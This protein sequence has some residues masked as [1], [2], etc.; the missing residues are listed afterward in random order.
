MSRGGGHW[1]LL[2]LVKGN[3]GT[4]APLSQVQRLEEELAAE[5]Q[6]AENMLGQAI[7]RWQY[8]EFQLV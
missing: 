7:R 6:R 8:L 3:E 1:R 4:S 5:R 2:M